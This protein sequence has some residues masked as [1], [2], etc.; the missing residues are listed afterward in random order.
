MSICF[1]DY[2]RKLDG[3]F[4][5][6]CGRHRPRMKHF[7]RLL[8][9]KTG[10][11]SIGYCEKIFIFVFLGLV[12]FFSPS[13]CFSLRIAPGLWS[14]HMVMNSD[15][16]SW[17]LSINISLVGKEE[18]CLLCKQ[19]KCKKFCTILVMSL[20][21]ISPSFV[22]LSSPFSSL[23]IAKFEIIRQNENQVSAR[24]IFQIFPET[25]KASKPAAAGH[26]NKQKNKCVSNVG[27]FLL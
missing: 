16:F 3:L 18:N 1:F 24:D 21:Q 13:I 11:F 6:K 15:V 25:A 27:K 22:V 5:R 10:H 14:S 4:G 23:S 2:H 17:F 9:L 20:L 8:S 7:Q 12:S 26:A 19:G